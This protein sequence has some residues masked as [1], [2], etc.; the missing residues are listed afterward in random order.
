MN[1]TSNPLPT[2]QLLATGGTIASKF[3]AATQDVRVDAFAEDLAAAVWRRI[4]SVRIASEDVL[5]IASFEMDLD[6]AFGVARRI[7]A[8]LERSDVAGVV[9][10]H[11]TDTLEETAFLA[12]LLIDSDKP[13]V[14]T[15]AQRAADD[16]DSDGPRNLLDAIAVAASPSARGF[17]SLVVFDGDIHCA[18][19]VVKSHASRLTA[20]ESPDVG[21]TGEIHDGRVLFYRGPP[22]RPVF[23]HWRIEPRVDLIKLAIGAD[24][25]FVDCAVT[26]GARGVVLEAFGRG[27][28]T[29]KVLEAVH[30]AV[31]A[32]VSVV[33]TTRCG[34][35]R[36]APMYGG[37]GGATLARAG[38]H[39]A[40]R[41]TG[42]KA[43]ILLA[44][45]LGRDSAAAEI[46]Q[47]LQW[48]AA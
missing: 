48:L 11:G 35:G 5:N 42:V 12:D 36:V 23:G 30:R 3:A 4:P 6:M 39:F 28:V 16:P 9:V 29:P 32:G 24:S 33:I 44:V 15:G 40:G 21:R 27:N 31:A 22:Y 46:E 26:S 47:G 34:R 43:R 2:I 19:D 7:D 10:T 20:F 14:F 25:R 18:R 41:L 38:A 37:S 8:S 1:D 45:L 13:V 17:G